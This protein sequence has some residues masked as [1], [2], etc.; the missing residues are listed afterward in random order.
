[1]T[2]LFLAEGFLQFGIGDLAARLRCSRS[3][4]YLVASSKEQIFLAA[5]RHFFRR[6]TT[7]IETLVAN[8][9]SPRSRLSTYLNA[10]AAELAPAS[11]G[12]YSDVAAF[13][14]ANEVYEEN[15]M[16]A[17]ARVGELVK[18][19]IDAGELRAASAAFV[20]V[21]VAEVMK[22][23][24]DGRVDAAANMSDS[25]A[26]QALTDLVINGLRPHEG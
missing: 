20:G 9:P 18:E 21:A 23:I 7:R 14:P 16:R 10:V 11:E 25:D 13:A 19:G 22:A 8:D 3:T 24:Q 12:F 17:A 26:Y 4:L 2:E 15:T 1:M 5:V 6:A